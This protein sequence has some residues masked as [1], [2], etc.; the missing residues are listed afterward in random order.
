MNQVKDAN[1][2]TAIRDQLHNIK[3]VKVVTSE[4]F[5]FGPD[6]SPRKDLYIYR[7]DKDGVHYEVTL[8]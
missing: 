1:N 6:N 2:G 3:S 7:I 8:K 5:S 4:H